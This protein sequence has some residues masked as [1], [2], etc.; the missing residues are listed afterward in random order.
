[1]KFSVTKLA[2]ALVG[3]SEPTPDGNLP[4]SS[5]DLTPALRDVM[6]D[7]IH[8]FQHGVEPARVI[9]EALSKAL[10]PYYPVAGRLLK[11][12]G[13]DMVVAC[14]GEGARFVEATANFS[15]KDVND[16]QRPL[17]IPKE[18]FLPVLPPDESKEGVIFM[19]Q[20]TQFTCGGFSVGIISSHAVFDGLGAAQFVNA[21]AEMARGLPRPTVEVIWCR[22]AIPTF[23]PAKP[24]QGP[25]PT[26]TAFDFE[27]SIAD[28][29]SDS[30]NQ[31]KDQYMNETGQRCSTFDIV[32]AMAWRA[33]TR[34][35]K[36][37]PDV[38]VR[39]GFAADT[40]HLLDQVIPHRKGYYGNAVY[41]VTVSATSEKIVSSSVVGIVSLIREA[42]KM[43]PIKFSKWMAGENE[44][45]PY[46]VPFDYG[47]FIIADWN[48]VGF[49]EVDYGW[50]EPMHVVP[51][52]DGNFIGSFI[53]LK[54][55]VP[56]QGVR[57]MMR[58]VVKEHLDVFN[59]EITNLA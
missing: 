36:L 6:V 50:G 35:I 18:E 7:S 49:Y 46:K 40:R 47:T 31:F 59:D 24:P 27:Y 17:M 39:F 13:G 12:D 4:L 48:K 2:P 55:P 19:M 22:E 9:R 1:M 23:D 56:K 54:P 14:T 52:N 3:P 26:L 41:P 44:E 38:E 28:I 42:K 58:C 45:D 20:V 53:I 30:I 51:F 29:S 10:V 11:C 34:A 33:R 43:L 5:I 16:L 32:T 8:V 57:L 15:L 21:I 25:P 37:E